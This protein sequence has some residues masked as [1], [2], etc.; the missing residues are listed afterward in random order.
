MN[1]WDAL[2]NQPLYIDEKEKKDP[3]LVLQE[4]AR[5]DDLMSQ[6]TLYLNI[7]NAAME[8]GK[9]LS[10]PGR[11]WFPDFILFIKLIEASYQIEELRQ[12]DRLI[13]LLK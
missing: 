2:F 6:R 4:F 9:L 13:Y 1:Y 8:S 3:F 10:V 11:P 12:S 7:Y 5:R